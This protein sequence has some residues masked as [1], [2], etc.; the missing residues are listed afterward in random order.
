MPRLHHLVAGLSALG[1]LVL[2]LH[3]HPSGSTD[4]VT[5]GTVRVEA[6]THVTINLLDDRGVIQQVVREY[7]TPAGTGSGFTVS[8]DGVVVTATG[9]VRPAKDP[10]VYAANRVFAEHFKVK[11]PADFSRHKLKNPELNARLQACYPPRNSHC[12]VTTNLK[13][14]VFPYADPPVSEGYPADLLHSGGSPG[15]PAV[16]KL[17]KGGEDGTLPTVPLGTTLGSGIESV[18][19]AG[20]PSR[21]SAKNPPVLQTAHLDPPGGRTFKPA[22]RDKLAA[23]L[24]A[25]GEGAA[26]IDDTKSEVVGLLTGSG[27]AATL[28]PVDDIRSA[29][30]A[31][32][33]TARRGPV[34]VVYETALA[35]FHNKS[36]AGAIPV[37]EQVLRLRPDHV[38]AQD[39]LRTA[40]AARGG[41]GTVSPGPST[42]PPAVTGS[43]AGSASRLLLPVSAGVVALAAM[44]AVAVPLMLRRRRRVA[45]VTP[46]GLTDPHGPREFAQLAE[47]AELGEFAEPG[48]FREPLPAGSPGTGGFP[49]TSGH[50]GADGAYG[51]GGPVGAAGASFPGGS[52]DSGGSS[53]SPGAA[54]PAGS[55]PGAAGVPSPGG[56]SWPPQGTQAM[57][58]PYPAERAGDPS[59]PA[60]V[61]VPAPGGTQA[62]FCTQCGMR[63]GKAHRFCGFCGNPV[64]Q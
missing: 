21:P 51:Y 58:P 36:Y 24:K 20:L 19:T 35:P 32:D 59:P 33:V 61:P 26:V 3:P 30:V 53:G 56:A 9:V 34:D 42:T 43:S 25:D 27:G 60:G 22:E 28:T 13:I 4:R 48:G 29:L 54:Q 39:H 57:E 52:G 11:V 38:V 46:G 12:I 63:L 15:S 16:L 18:D 23:F 45:A 47:H 49:A 41:A 50:S 2:T 44:V 17:A 5:P 7:D 40:R 6:T 10:A 31:A 14:T 37:L 62:R 8:P 1:S 64:E 55:A